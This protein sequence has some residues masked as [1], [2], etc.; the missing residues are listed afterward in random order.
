MTSHATA[1]RTVAAPAPTKVMFLNSCVSGGGAGR[2]LEAL[3]S[4]KDPRIQATV[5]MPEPG[6]LAP[7]ITHAAELVY[8]P[9]FVERLRR[10]PYRWPDRWRLPALHLLAN[11]VALPV[12]AFKMWQW[13]RR[14]RPRVIH[15]NHMLAKPLGALLGALTGTPVVFHSRACHHLWLD[16]AF[17]SWLGRRAAVRRIICNSDAS[18]QVYRRHS[19]DKVRIV[20]NSIDLD[21]F[22]RGTVTPRLRSTYGI[23]ADAFVVGFVGRIHAKKGL[24]WLLQSFVAVAAEKPSARLV[25]VGGNDGSLHHDGLAQYRQLAHALG[26]SD[27]QLVFTG[28]QDDVRGFVADFDLL[29]FPSVQPESFGRVLLEAMA[30][31]VPVVTSAHGGAIEVVRDGEEGLWVPVG[32]VAAL[33]GAMLALAGDAERRRA[34]GQRGRQR[35]LACYDRQAIAGQVFDVLVDVA[36]AARPAAAPAQRAPSSA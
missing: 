10:S 36:A 17:Y 16:A 1:A 15:C 18:A 11:A 14:E 12:A 31:E 21:H 33:A 25:I 29:V 30:L 9:E 4:V 19:A 2:S 35:V 27:G 24:A 8:V 20:P 28:Y 6:V 3:L 34:M 7:K 22:H 13:V 5:F 23:A 26:L 32:D